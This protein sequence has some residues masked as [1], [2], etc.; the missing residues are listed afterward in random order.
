[1][2]RKKKT[3]KTR[4][5]ILEAYE[6]NEYANVLQNRNRARS[7]TV[8]TAFGGSVEVA[9]RGDHSNLWC[10]LQPVEAIEMIEQLAAAVGVQ[11]AMRPKNDFSTW[12]GWDDTMVENKY[13]IGTQREQYRLSAEKEEPNSAKAHIS[14]F[15]DGLSEE[16]IK[17]IKE[18]G[19]ENQQREKEILEDLNKNTKE[20]CNSQFVEYVERKVEED[21]CK[22]EIS[23]DASSEKIQFI[24]DFRKDL[25]QDIKEYAEENG[26]N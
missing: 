15:L 10:I 19:E 20:S 23:K 9:L 7:F 18:I 16:A 12:R 8:G 26:L 13:W 2:E 17:Y 1:M 4:K 14:N 11:V 24:E 22:K 6:Q 25:D 5:K 21:K 3:S